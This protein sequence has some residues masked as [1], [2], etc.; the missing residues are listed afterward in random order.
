[1]KAPRGYRFVT[2]GRFKPGDKV[3]WIGIDGDW[4]TFDIEAGCF[5][6]GLSV[7]D[8]LKRWVGKEQLFV[9]RKKVKA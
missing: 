6:H 8:N 7:A 9:L 3:G 2:K 5:L 1:M 4:R